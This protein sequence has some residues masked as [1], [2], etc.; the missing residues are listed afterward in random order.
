MINCLKSALIILL[1]LSL[2]DIHAQIRSDYLFGVN[3]STLSIK[4]KDANIN[5]ES[6][7][8]IHFGGYYEIPV[9][10]HFALQP[11]LIFSAKGSDYKIDTITIS[12]APSYIELPINGLLSFD[13]KFA[14]VSLFSGPYF[15]YAFGG[16]KNETGFPFKCISYG[17][18]KNHDL[19]HFDIGLNLGARLRIKEYEF[20]VQY[21]LGF[22]NISPVGGFNTEMK[23]RVVGF[24]I[25]R[26]GRI[27]DF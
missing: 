20:S 17:S 9:S 1:T 21:G 14:K 7:A 8:G 23:N 6:V 11:S 26:K 5:P 24:S 10:K 16:Y 4:I 15:A 27:T 22:S 18:G 2:S 25:L 13:L 12:L 3:F 19:R